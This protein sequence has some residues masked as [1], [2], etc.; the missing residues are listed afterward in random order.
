MFI[1]FLSG[2]FTWS[3][4]EYVMHR[5]AGHRRTGLHFSIDHLQH[6]RDPEY[7]V[8]MSKKAVR[9]LKA[10]AALTL[11]TWLLTTLLT[12]MI[13]ALGFIAAYGY[14][15]WLH[16]AIH[17]HGPRNRY[18]RWARRHHLY[19]HFGDMRV[20]HGVTSPVWD[21]VFG[22]YVAATVVKIPRKKADSWLKT[23]IDTASSDG[24]LEDYQLI[25][26]R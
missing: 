7:F 14:Y 2:C 18:G 22:T 6:H 13:F 25:S 20:N 12:G 8:S 16:I 3:L 5:F 23:A 21:M 17:A 24:W 9:A 26:A 15:E 19:H 4:T 1:A 10:Y 11:V